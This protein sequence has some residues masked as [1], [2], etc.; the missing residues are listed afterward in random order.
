M[1][2]VVCVLYITVDTAVDMVTAYVIVVITIVTIAI[3]IIITSSS[4]SHCIKQQQ[5]YIARMALTSEHEASMRR[6]V[7]LKANAFFQGEVL[8]GMLAP[9]LSAGTG[10]VGER[11]SNSPI[12]SP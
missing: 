7:S 9:H 2:T 4:S 12:H 5:A 10:K 11:F 8:S 1:M 6:L 3:V